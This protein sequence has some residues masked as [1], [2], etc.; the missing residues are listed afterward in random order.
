MNYIKFYDDIRVIDRELKREKYPNATS[1]GKKLGWKNRKTISRLLQIMK[2]D[3]GAPIDYDESKKGYYYTD[4]NC[5][6][7]NTF[8]THKDVAILKIIEKF[9]KDEF[10]CTFLNGFNDICSKFLLG[11]KNEKEDSFL[12][13]LESNMAFSPS[14]KAIINED[15]LFKLIDA[16][17]FEEKAIITYRSQKDEV[18]TRKVHPYKIIYKNGCWYIIAY[19]ETRNN[20]QL[21]A[22]H[23]ISSIDVIEEDY[24]EKPEN[25][26]IKIG[27]G[28]DSLSGKGDY[29]VVIKI[30]PEAAAYVRDR[31]WHN[32]QTITENPDKSIN[33]SFRLHTL[34]NVRRWILGFGGNA[35]VISPPELR[36][37]TLKDA[38]QIVGRYKSN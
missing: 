18:L 7:I 22:I 17:Y 23:N 13:E 31:F 36:D 28:I 3:F 25:L 9:I 2:E 15:V 19:C 11:E 8:V 14:P 21:F 32:T 6:M 27:H 30:M 34:N 20:V 26:N 5:I 37:L 1:L 16:V 10:G 4:K 38:E 35:E 12:A 29:E 33:I 24:F